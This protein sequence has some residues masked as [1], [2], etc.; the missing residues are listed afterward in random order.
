MYIGMLHNWIKF[1]T[2]NLP[3]LAFFD[4]WG[5][6]CAGFIPIWPVRLKI[7][8]ARNK[9]SSPL[10]WFRREINPAPLR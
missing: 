5:I 10:G 3:D 8:K 2:N 7:I 9:K 6:Y 4:G 1:T